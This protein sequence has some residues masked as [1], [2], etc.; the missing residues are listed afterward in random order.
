MRKD[1]KLGFAIG[2]ILLSVLVVYA[3]ISSQ[4]QATPEAIQLSTTD[5]SAKPVQSEPPAINLAPIQLNH[6]AVASLVPATQPAPA[7]PQPALPPI[8][9]QSNESKPAGNDPWGNVLSN[10]M[11][12]MTETPS[13]KPVADVSGA[14]QSHNPAPGG[15]AEVNPGAPAS[16][17]PLS[18]MTSGSPSTGPA[19]IEQTAPSTPRTH[20]IRSGE[21]FWTIAA[22][23]YG[24]SAYAPQLIRANPTVDPRNLKVGS[25]INVPPKDQVA[26]AMSTV[27]AQA[28]SAQPLDVKTSYRVE[29]GDSLYRISVKLYGKPTEMDKL[30]DLNKSIIGPDRTKLHVGMVLKLPQAPIAKSQ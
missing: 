11:T 9:A 8:A 16:N 27:T 7:T 30:Y 29:T 6:D 10:G 28:N 25:V 5:D 1:V 13:P 19:A 26:S 18:M 20:V 21:N 15:G 2:G 17:R 4:G 22:A 12:M 23:V 3:L 14:T 24:N